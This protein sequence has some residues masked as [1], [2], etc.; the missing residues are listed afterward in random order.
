MNKDRP[1]LLQNSSSREKLGSNAVE[2]VI[3]V[4]K[5]RIGGRN[6]WQHVVADHLLCMELH[7]FSMV[8]LGGALVWQVH[9]KL[10]Q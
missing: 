1:C 3:S 6:P 4:L 10:P 9:L 7:S 8:A 5:K 2:F